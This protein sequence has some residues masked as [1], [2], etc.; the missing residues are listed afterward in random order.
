MVQKITKIIIKQNS[1]GL[2]TFHAI[3]NQ[4][5]CQNRVK[6]NIC[7]L[8]KSWNMLAT[9]FVTHNYSFFNKIHASLPSP[10]KIYKAGLKQVLQVELKAINAPLTRCSIKQLWGVPTA[11]NDTYFMLALLRR[12]SSSGHLLS[13]IFQPSFTHYI[14]RFY[15]YTWKLLRFSCLLH[16]HPWILL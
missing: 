6:N 3:M 1:I 4:R 7:L 16:C 15:T 2:S 12:T 9:C 14:Y 10:G 5:S 8:C 11:F 13:P